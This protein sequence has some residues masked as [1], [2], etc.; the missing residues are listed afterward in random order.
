M[1]R[2]RVLCQVHHELAE[3]TQ[4]ELHEDGPDAKIRLRARRRHAALAARTPYLCTHA[5]PATQSQLRARA[6]TPVLARRRPHDLGQQSRAIP[7]L[8]SRA[9]RPL[10]E[11]RI[12]ADALHAILPHQ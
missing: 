6:P 8:R 9:H 2:T 1:V 10:H 4:H 5:A 3:R 7:H 12:G 11:L